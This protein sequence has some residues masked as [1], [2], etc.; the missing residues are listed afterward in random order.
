MEKNIDEKNL[1]FKRVGEGDPAGA[2]EAMLMRVG[3]GPDA[4]YFF[5]MSGGE[6]YGSF[7]SNVV[8]ITKKD[9]DQIYYMNSAGLAQAFLE[10]NGH[11]IW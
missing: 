11:V 10:K 3:S 1:R 6:D 5:L 7:I 9:Y 8:E 4:R 2:D